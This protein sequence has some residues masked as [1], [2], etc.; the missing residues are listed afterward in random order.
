MCV[1]TGVFV[2]GEI[3][4][5]VYLCVCTGEMR[6]WKV[7]WWFVWGG[8]CRDGLVVFERTYK[9]SMGK[10]QVC[11]CMEGEMGL[12]VCVCVR[13][14]CG[15]GGRDGR[16]PAVCVGRKDTV[17]VCACVCVLETWGC[18]CTHMERWGCV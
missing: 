5:C 11:V 8:L 6:L 4:M 16:I 3:G 12:C 14:V 9:E 13:P 1:E 7:R 2:E 10:T 18:R 17:W 15:C